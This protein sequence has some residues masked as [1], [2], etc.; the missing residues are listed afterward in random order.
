MKCACRNESVINPK[1]EKIRMNNEVKQNERL[2]TVEEASKILGLSS[3][4]IRYE[5]FIGRIPHVK[6]GRSVRFTK[7]QLASWISSNSKNGSVK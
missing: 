7:E 3:H 1:Q 6:L 5:V 2:I 4:R